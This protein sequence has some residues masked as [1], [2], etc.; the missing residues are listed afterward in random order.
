MQGHGKMV[1]QKAEHSTYSVP[2]FRSAVP[3]RNSVERKTASIGIYDKKTG[4]LFHSVGTGP[5]LCHHPR[6]LERGGV[7]QRNKAV[8]CGAK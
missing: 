6:F 8:L 7:E 2:L 4:T 3:M 1:E 5:S